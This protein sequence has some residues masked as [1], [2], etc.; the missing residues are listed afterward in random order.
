[1]KVSN[2]YRVYFDKDKLRFNTFYKQSDKKKNIKLNDN[3]DINCNLVLNKYIDYEYE[4]KTQY[5][6][7]KK[8]K[9]KVKDKNGDYIIKEDTVGKFSKKFKLIE[10]HKLKDSYEILNYINDK[11]GKIIDFYKK[12]KYNPIE[13]T[14]QTTSNLAIGHGEVSFRE[15]S[16][17]LDHIYGVPFIPA[18][19]IKGAFKKYLEEKRIDTSQLITIFGS[20]DKKGQ[21]IF[22]DIYPENYEIGIDIMTPH[23]GDYYSKDKAPTDDMVPV[24]IKFPVVKEETKFKFIILYNEKLEELSIKQK[25]KEFLN[26]TPLGAKTSVG[27]GYFEKG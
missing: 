16:I 5:N 10:K 4:F 24:P 27:Y 12:H 2:E 8:K 18:S 26:T 11:K 9:E 20:E 17:K 19:S 6:K 22:L 1:M 7:E 25:F 21:V 23:F 3:N 14:Y 13:I 15:V